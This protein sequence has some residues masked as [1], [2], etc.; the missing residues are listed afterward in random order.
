MEESINDES[1]RMAGILFILPTVVIGGV[2]ILTL[3]INDPKYMKQTHRIYYNSALKQ[4]AREL[5]NNSTLSEVLLWNELKNKKL[6]GFDFHRQKPIDNYIVDFFCYTLMLAIEIDGI[7][8]GG[9]EEKDEKRQ[10]GLEGL[11]IRFLRF[12]DLMI[13]R[14]IV[15]VLREIEIWIDENYKPII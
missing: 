12:D 3:L 11:G 10:K 2:S 6:R 4:K 13:K 5:R 9:K 15:S 1:K 8:H 7:S 14:N